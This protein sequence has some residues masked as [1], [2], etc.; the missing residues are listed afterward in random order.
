MGFLCW[1]CC[2]NFSIAMNVVFFLLFHIFFVLMTLDNWCGHTIW[3]CAH[4]NMYIYIFVILVSIWYGEPFTLYNF[5]VFSMFNTV[6]VHYLHTT[7]ALVILPFIGIHIGILV[8]F[9]MVYFS[10]FSYTLL[11][12]CWTV[13][14]VVIRS[15]NVVTGMLLAPLYHAAHFLLDCFSA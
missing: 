11:H 15:F 7:T 4:D 5:W 12:G 14:T 1:T 3:S 13:A 2:S 8:L 6:H 10:E 9:N